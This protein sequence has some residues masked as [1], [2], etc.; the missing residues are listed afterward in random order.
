MDVTDILMQVRFKKEF[1]SLAVFVRFLQYH[2]KSFCF[3]IAISRLSS[4]RNY[5]SDVK[6]SAATFKFSKN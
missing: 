1:R 3:E 6:I 5:Q 4:N 2:D